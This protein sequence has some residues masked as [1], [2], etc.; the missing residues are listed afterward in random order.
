[1]VVGVDFLFPCFFRFFSGK[2]LVAAAVDLDEDL[3]KDLDKDSSSFLWS[4]AALYSSP[5]RATRG[6][7]AFSY[8]CLVAAMLF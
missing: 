3:D 1:M 6:I 8:F 5:R 4:G 2:E 7:Q